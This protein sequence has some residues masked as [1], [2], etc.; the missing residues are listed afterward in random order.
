MVGR[1]E[2]TKTVRCCGWV[3]AGDGA[4]VV[5]ERLLSLVGLRSYGEGGDKGSV[6]FDYGGALD[7]CL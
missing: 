4:T 5:G 7:A 1:V 6:G 3:A 2:L